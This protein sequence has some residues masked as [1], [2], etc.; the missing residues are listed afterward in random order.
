[1]SD[2]IALRGVRAR[3][4]HGVLDDERAHGQ[5]FLVDVVLHAET[6][7]AARADDLAGTVD[8]AEVA[9]RVVAIVEGEPVRLVETLAQ[10]IAD[11]CLSDL[12]VEQVEVTVHKPQAPLPVSFE[13]V[14][15]TI[16]RRR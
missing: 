6:G 7:P 14:S 2:R 8:Y 1:M 15:V 3:G 12:R 10:R 13:D 9:A 16:A 11:A 5:E 4:R